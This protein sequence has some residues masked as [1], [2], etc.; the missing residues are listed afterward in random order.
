MSEV[1]SGTKPSKLV[2]K[3]EK[4]QSAVS[5]I[6]IVDKREDYDYIGVLYDIASMYLK[7]VNVPSLALCMIIA[8]E[9]FSNLGRLLLE[10]LDCDK[11][12]D[13]R[14][15]LLMEIDGSFEKPSNRLERLLSDSE[16]WG[17][18]RRFFQELSFAISP[19]ILAWSN[20]ID[21]VAK[22]F[23]LA[24]VE[25]GL[26]PHLERESNGLT[27]GKKLSGT[28]ELEVI[29]R[30]K[31]CRIGIYKIAIN[32]LEMA[33]ASKEDFGRRPLIENLNLIRTIRIMF[34]LC[35]SDGGVPVKFGQLHVNDESGYAM[36]SLLHVDLQLNPIEI[37]ER[38]FKPMWTAI[39][40]HLIAQD[41]ADGIQEEIWSKNKEAPAQFLQKRPYFNM[42]WT[43]QSQVA[44]QA[45][46]YQQA[47]TSHWT[48]TELTSQIAQGN[49]IAIDM[50]AKKLAATDEFSI[51]VAPE[52]NTEL[53]SSSCKEEREQLARYKILREPL[54]LPRLG[55]LSEIEGIGTQLKSE[56]PWAHDAIDEL[57]GDLW[58]RRAFGN[59]QASMQAT[60]L[61][62][63]PGCG[64]TRLARRLSELLG[65][66][67]LSIGMTDGV[68][69]VL[70]GTTRGW[71]SARCGSIVDMLA[72]RRV[73]GGLVLLDEIDKVSIGGSPRSAGT[74]AILM[75]LLEPENA[76]RFYDVF[77]L[78]NVNLSGVS[79]IATANN[80]DKMP[81]ALMSRLRPV[82]V[83]KPR[84]EHLQALAQGMLSDIATQWGVPIEAMPQLPN[85]DLQESMSAREIR[86]LVQQWL[87]RWAMDHRKSGLH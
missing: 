79:F 76:A 61:V 68:D 39:M 63:P 83:G 70:E 66:A 51:V 75:Q 16:E 29:N 59:V 15:T 62:G 43:E 1:K 84:Q 73:G 31:D 32:V 5:I 23:G 80:L 46:L 69:K 33:M 36:Q 28:S 6:E 81:G 19:S 53:M 21:E 2:R 86:L 3:D 10:F 77:L 20:R 12:Q 50:P 49:V 48:W 26:L 42:R 27:L 57:V 8:P 65:M 56:F 60:L 78:T 64:K 41:E 24:I 30:F 40:H 17:N 9:S 47:A 34:G 74:L 67:S 55:S 87:K 37:Y 7:N 18:A 82:F 13:R 38:V 35:L 45:S 25:D 11:D 52:L 71:A 72:S 54:P 22:H 14:K 4:S 85:L 44:I 58:G